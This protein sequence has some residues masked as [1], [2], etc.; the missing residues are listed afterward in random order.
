M[1]GLFLDYNAAVLPVTTS[2]PPSFPPQSTAFSRFH[3]LRYSA[4]S[5]GPAFVSYCPNVLSMF[6]D[7]NG[8]SCRVICQD[9]DHMCAIR[10]NGPRIERTL[11]SFNPCG[12]TYVLTRE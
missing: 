1:T 9:Y 10:T 7:T 5:R 12:T 2:H 6:S 8:V 11:K 4:G 3:L